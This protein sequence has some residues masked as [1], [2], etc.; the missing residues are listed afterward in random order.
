M[1]LWVFISEMN[2]KWE[3]IIEKQYWITFLQ[4]VGSE[5]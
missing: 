4:L 3:L 1:V 5:G 2:G